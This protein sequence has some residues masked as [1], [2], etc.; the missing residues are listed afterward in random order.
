[1][2]SS[3]LALII[4]LASTAT[5][6]AAP[7]AL[8]TVGVRIEPQAAAP[9]N[10]TL[11][12]VGL[13]SPNIGGDTGKPLWRNADGTD[14]VLGAGGGGAGLTWPLTNGSNPLTFTSGVANGASSVAHVLDTTNALNNATAKH[15]SIRDAGIE[16][17][18][19]KAGNSAI[20]FTSNGNLTLQAAGG[21]PYFSIQSGITYL[22]PNGGAAPFAWTSTVFGQ[23][24]TDNAFTVG[25]ATHRYATMYSVAVNSGGSALGLTSGGLIQFTANGNVNVMQVQG[26][27]VNPNNDNATPLGTTGQRWLSVGTVAIN[28]GASTLTQTSTVATGASRAGFVLVDGN[29]NLGADKFLSIQNTANGERIYI[30]DGLIAS[31]SGGLNIRGVTTASLQAGSGA[32]VA[33]T[34]SSFALTNS[35]NLLTLGDASH[36]WATT[37]TLAIN[38][39]ASTLTHMSGI[40]DAGS[41]VGHIFD[42]T[43]AIGGVTRIAQF[44]N[45]GAVKFYVSSD[46]KIGWDPTYF[47]ALF[48]ANAQ[49]LAISNY[50]GSGLWYINDVY[51]GTSGDNLRSL[52][53][54]AQ[55][56]TNVYTYD[57]DM[58][59]T[60]KWNNA[61]NAQTTVGAA[62][63]ASALPATPTK[64]LKVKDSAGTTYVIPAYAP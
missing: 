21:T 32:V 22:A 56:F 36:R 54:T 57:L 62:G 29:N 50:G 20:V 63:G 5:A 16:R 30:A 25:D 10:L 51:L 8:K 24:Q 40:A 2:R 31:L 1:M 45:G 18:Y 59:G 47:T 17:G 7:L 58:Q 33:I 42:T 28:S 49:T 6:R 52:G 34:N 27:A 64:Y 4:A 9:G 13:W 38:S 41:N 48:Q 37:H 23:P 3:R 43:N 19:I 53:Q 12:R 44:K 60:P 39:G 55:R 46:G 35:D 26:G 14:T 61:A 11:G 15:L